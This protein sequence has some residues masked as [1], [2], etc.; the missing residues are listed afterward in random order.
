M[1]AEIA[2]V[3][4]TA[5]ADSPRYGRR[6][7]RQAP[8]ESTVDAL[9]DLICLL[10]AAGRIVR[11]N[12]V[13]ERWDL[14]PLADALA[15]DLHGVLHIG[16]TAPSCELLTALGTAWQSLADGQS[17]QFELRDP[18]LG[19]A[20]QVII[21]RIDGGDWLAVAVVTDVTALYLAREAL[22]AMNAELEMRVRL[23][24]DALA[25][26]NS[27]LQ[28]EIVRR[29]A[30]EQALRRSR[31]ELAA[32]SHQLITA[33][34]A[35]RT[36]IA[37]EL[38]DSVGQQLGAIKYSLE[39]VELSQQ[40]P[41]EASPILQR[42]IAALQDAMQD[43]RDIAMDLRP[44]VLDDLGAASA[45]SWFCRQF[46]VSYP[47]FQ[48]SERLSVVDADIPQRL[49]TTVFRSLQELLNNV[50]KHSQARAV[51]VT[52]ARVPEGLILEVVDDGVGIAAA[53][54]DGPGKVRARDPQSAR[55]RRDDGRSA[56][57]AAVRAGRRHAGAGGVA[58]RARRLPGARRSLGRRALG[59]RTRAVLFFGE[60]QARA[61][62]QAVAYR[63]QG[64]GSGVMQLEF[65]HQI[66][67]VFFH[68]LDAQA[69][70]QRDS[71]VGLAKRHARQYLAFALGDARAGLGGGE[72]APQVAGH[73]TRRYRFGEVLL[74]ADHGAD[75]LQQLGTAG[76]LEHIAVGAGTQGGTDVFIGAVG[77][78]HQDL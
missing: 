11:I 47:T 76:V 9:P 65:T 8:W 29:E 59:L 75:G 38:H 42:G 16:C 24:T 31:N 55:A 60:L 32:L 17:P 71:L 45:V 74:A 13:V 18:R 67:A 21:R 56:V 34:E 12:R 51:V 68:R 10:D 14:C 36:R 2:G 61:R 22:N 40:H 37:R 7:A 49:G 26:A 1:T 57:A 43:L 70:C 4:T 25:A 52:L 48:V 30:A 20:L 33:Q 41:E 54:L 28:N 6:L 62:Q 64:H 19:R 73:E 72:I 63:E 46:A 3:A 58:A 66:G 78:Q 39:R 5:P 23:R 53:G 15:R 27:D 50:A 77:G 35:E 44:A 69:Q